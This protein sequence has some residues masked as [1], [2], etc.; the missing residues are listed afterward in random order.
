MLRS[1]CWLAF[2]VGCHGSSCGSQT[3]TMKQ[4]LELA[5]IRAKGPMDWTLMRVDGYEERLQNEGASRVESRAMGLEE[6]GPL[7]VLT[8]AEYPEDTLISVRRAVDDLIARTRERLEEDAQVEGFEASA[9]CAEIFCLSDV[10]YRRDEQFQHVRLITWRQERV[11]STRECACMNAG[12][13]MAECELPSPPADADDVDATGPTTTDVVGGIAIDVG[14][15]WVRYPELEEG[16]RSGV[17]DDFVSV[18]SLVYGPEGAARPMATAAL[19]RFTRSPRSVRR[20]VQLAADGT[21]QRFE[22]EGFE[23]HVSI[24][25]RS[26][27]CEVEYDAV[28]GARRT[29]GR[30]RTWITT[31]HRVEAMCT[32]TADGYELLGNCVL[33]EPPANALSVDTVP[34]LSAP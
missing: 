30:S 17:G 1:G 34:A 28:A 12:C 4:T 29:R 15:D 9:E 5:G 10:Q 20:L 2:V 19:F 18:E 21:R 14:R 7:V 23:A 8:A 24:E 31:E 16:F 11:R 22:G 33:P 13:V 26:R 25:C 32:G 3:V 27:Y 6:V